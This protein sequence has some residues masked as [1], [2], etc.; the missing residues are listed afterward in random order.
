[1][2]KKAVKMILDLVMTL[3]I[4]LLMNL[5]TTGLALHELLGL[6][7][8]VL[9]LVHKALNWAWIRAVSKNLFRKETPAK[10]KFLYM[11]NV[12]VFLSVTVMIGSGV[13]I[14]ESLFHF[15]LAGGLRPL[16]SALHRSAAYTSLVLISVH[17]GMHW[18]AIV[19]T[20]KKW[21]GLSGVKRA[22]TIAARFTAV[23]IMLAG[24]KAS[25]DRNVAGEIVS[26]LT[27]AKDTGESRQNQYNYRKNHS[28][29]NAA[30]VSTVASAS[31]SLEDY[32]SGLTCTACGRH[33]PLSAPQCG[34]GSQQAATAETEYYSR[35]G[36]SG[37][38]TQQSGDAAR[39][40][41]GSADSALGFLDFIPI[42]GLFVGG[43]HYTVL[44]TKKKKETPSVPRLPG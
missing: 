35:N 19:K 36:G 12:L 29:L 40:G 32:L 3:L 27:Q 41:A 18:A 15:T 14:S 11:L 9:F 26:P 37:E 31:Q 30:A 13:L 23:C 25:A 5:A 44:L 1:M 43:T 34:R 8:G 28:T 39:G 33:C 42:M 21:M 38:N 24:V 22:R 4:V 7:A 17:L 6:F 16:V 2:P 20:V 10:T